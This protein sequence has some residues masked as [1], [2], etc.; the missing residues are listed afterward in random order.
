MVIS[1]FTRD[2]MSDTNTSALST[3][4][5]IGHLDKL[6]PKGGSFVT[7]GSD[8]PGMILAAGG[9]YGSHC[10]VRISV[11]VP[12]IFGLASDMFNLNWF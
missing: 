4:E 11:T 8:V 2:G 12:E 3:A 1:Q 10:N 5:I 7:C 6:T 9:R